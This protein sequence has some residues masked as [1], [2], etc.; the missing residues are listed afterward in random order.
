MPSEKKTKEMSDSARVAEC[1]KNIRIFELN[2]IQTNHSTRN[3][4]P[5]EN[6]IRI[7][8]SDE[9]VDARPMKKDFLKSCRSVGKTFQDKSANLKVVSE[10]LKRDQFFHENDQNRALQK[11]IIQNA[12]DGFRYSAP[13]FKNAT[14]LKI[15]IS[16]ENSEL[17]I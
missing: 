11:N 1:L 10:I 4:T 9:I 17:K 8:D 7:N 3:G 14:M 12:F 5:A 13:L 6:R 15:S 2:V 16:D